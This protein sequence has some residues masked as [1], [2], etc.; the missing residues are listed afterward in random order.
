MKASASS[1]VSLAALVHE[2]RTEQP[3]REGV[4][5]SSDPKSMARSSSVSARTSSASPIECRACRRAQRCHHARGAELDRRTAED[6]R[7]RSPA[8]PGRRRRRA[9]SSGSATSV[10]STNRICRCASSPRSARRRSRMQSGEIQRADDRLAVRADGDAPRAGPRGDPR[11][12]GGDL[13]RR[14]PR[15]VFRHVRPTCSRCRRLPPPVSR[16]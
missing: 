12:L 3:V 4:G 14:R 11:Q 2:A 6:A 5:R 1:S 15:W 13:C 10:S 8:H 16:G 9:T 7:R